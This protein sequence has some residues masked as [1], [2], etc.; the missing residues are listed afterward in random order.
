VSGEA[1]EPGSDLDE[2]AA[3]VL[4]KT[5]RASPALVGS[6]IFH[7]AIFALL[8][9]VVFYERLREPETI[10]ISIAVD[11][12]RIDPDRNYKPV[13]AGPPASDGRGLDEP[14]VFFPDALPAERN[15]SVSK[16]DRSAMQGDE[17]AVL[18]QTTNE[19][20][21]GARGRRNELGQF[22]V[23][24]TIGIG[25][26]SGRGATRFGGVHGGRRNLAARGGGSA[27]TEQA[28]DWGLSWLARHQAANGCFSTA[29]RCGKCGA[30]AQLPRCDVAA[31]GL[32]VVA[33]LTAGFT[34]QDPNLGVKD[35][36]TGEMHH[37]GRTVR[38]GLEWL[39]KQQRP[40]GLVGSPAW[41]SEGQWPTIMYGHAFATMALCDAARVS[42]AS[43]LRTAA[44]AAVRWLEKAQ[45]P[46]AGWQYQPRDG[47]SDLSVTGACVQA[48]RSAK[49]AGIEVSPSALDGVARLVASVS[50]E[51]GA[52]G[53]CIGA[54]RGSGTV[55]CTAIAFYARRF[56]G[57]KNLEDPKLDATKA[58]IA[59]SR[60]SADGA[61]N[62]YE[63][64]Y[65]M[66]ALFEVEGPGG[67]DF[68]KCNKA[69]T[70]LLLEKQQ[71]PTSGC[72]AGSWEIQ[73]DSYLR[74]SGRMVGTALNVLTLEVYY[75][76]VVGNP[77]PR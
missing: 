45:N 17:Q 6:L 57:D 15:E 56:L 5:F 39:M 74:E 63:D 54:K 49:M 75:R 29:N 4:R 43:D 59:G 50:D 22:G 9:L 16:V 20:I 40:D 67:A 31:T 24:D 21:S 52:A 46:G 37:Y 13:S 34:P 55:A 72:V 35:A 76:Y 47:K 48:L 53:Y 70:T 44:T 23:H 51:R 28:V 11:A 41:S 73:N 38:A 10:P 12:Q 65:S 42:S 32:A 19:E 71:K 36:A 7:G 2:L 8:P 61:T 68:K 25:G 77:S 60:G 66:L 30:A 62:Y 3:T 26:G 33:F 69:V 14:P 18:L 27:A 1:L 64:Y 58:F